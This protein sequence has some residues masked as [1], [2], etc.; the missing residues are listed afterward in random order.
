MS[1]KTTFLIIFFSLGFN[2]AYAI[3]F[4]DSTTALFAR[5]E[6]KAPAGL[7][8]YDKLDN[9]GGYY[10][11]YFP[12]PYGIILGCRYSS[13]F[14]QIKKNRLS[15]WSAF[16][17]Q[18]DNYTSGISYD[19][20][21]D[22]DSMI[23]RGNFNSKWGYSSEDFQIKQMLFTFQLGIKYNFRKIRPAIG[24]WF[25]ANLYS[26]TNADGVFWEQIPIF[27]NNARNSLINRYQHGIKLDLY[28]P[29]VK[30]LGIVT[31]LIGQFPIHHPNYKNIEWS[32]NA[33]SVHIGIDYKISK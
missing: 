18:Y 15:Y 5:I 8:L 21:P 7:Y 32:S 2:N 4:K 30:N 17:I 31:G 29:I 23:K 3:K 25:G 24:Y 27:K 12:K 13:T 33:G 16:D 9:I 19:S 28:I 20:F 26:K 14:K 10:G 1:F 6:Y 11:I 22:S